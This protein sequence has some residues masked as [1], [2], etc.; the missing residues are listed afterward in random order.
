MDKTSGNYLYMTERSYI[1]YFIKRY[2]SHGY[3]LVTSFLL[4]LYEVKYKSLHKIT[5]IY[6]NYSNIDA[7][8]CYI[9][10]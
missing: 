1:I 3:V 8:Y 6:F 7:I 2:K 9:I 5:K 4:Y 10:Q